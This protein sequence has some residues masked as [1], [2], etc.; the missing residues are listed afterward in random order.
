MEKQT[1]KKVTTFSFL[2]AAALAYLV[3]NIL[4]KSLASVSAVFQKLYS[5]DVLSHGLPVL[6]AA[7]LFFALQFNAKLLTW[8]EDVVLEISKVV[9]PSHRDTF[10]M[11]I[12]VC[13]FVS[14]ACVALL[15]IDFMARHFV[16][17][18]IR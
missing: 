2:C 15:F 3:V 9:W 13:V 1:V 17:F 6:A 18:I 10:A 14:I 12:V 7:A 8:A 16:E 11:T 4:F 5:M